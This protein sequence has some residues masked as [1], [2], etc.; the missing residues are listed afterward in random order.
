MEKLPLDGK[1][2]EVGRARTVSSEF[3]V[4]GASLRGTLA[5]GSF[6]IENPKL[7]FNALPV[8]NIGGEL[9]GRFAVTIDQKNRRIRFRESTPAE[10][11]LVPSP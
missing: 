5:I 3:V 4:H 2:V 1:P 11:S 10:R 9:L 6:R 7:R 8:P